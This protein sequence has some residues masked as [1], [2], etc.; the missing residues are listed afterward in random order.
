MD[1]Y[2]II[3]ILIFILTGLFFILKDK[4]EKKYKKEYEQKKEELRQYQSAEIHALTEHDNKKTLEELR[5]NEQKLRESRLE[6]ASITNEIELKRSFNSNLERLHKEDLEKIMQA[7]KEKLMAQT[8]QEVD[9]WSKSAQEA[10]TYEFNTIMTNYQNELDE[11]AEELRDLYAEVNEY[12]AKRRAINEEILRSRALN[13]KQDFYRIQIDE[14]AKHDIALIDSI[15]PQIYK[16]ETLNKLLYDNYI[17]KPTKDM[18]KRVLEGKDPTGVY[19]VTNIETN[20]VYIG[21][22]TSVG[23]RWINHVK[24]AEGLEGVADSQFQRALRDYGVENFT[25]E[26]LEEIPKDKLTE[27]EKYWIQ[28]FDTTHYGYNQRIG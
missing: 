26:L 19:K 4:L 6:L 13:E 5:Q 22:S 17:S 7:T 15:R 2:G 23:S 27:R 20:E 12:K 1:K 24:S 14:K 25:W 3:G 8:A 18:V 9:E 11:K 28:F 16:F 21:K 10:A